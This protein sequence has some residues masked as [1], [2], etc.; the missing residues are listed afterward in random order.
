MKQWKEEW[1]PFQPKELELIAPDTYMQRRNVEEVVHEETE[2]MPGYT[3]YKCE[4]REISVEEHEMLKSI[5][6]INTDKAI[7]EYTM[8]LIEEGVL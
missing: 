3:D 7:D 5:E 4:C 1:C 8:Q 2:D 6:E